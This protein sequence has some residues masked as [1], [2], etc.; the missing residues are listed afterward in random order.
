MAL[1]EVGHWTGQPD[2]LN[3]ATLAEGVAQ[4]VDSRAYP[5]EEL[6]AELHSYLSGCRL[7]V[8][9]DPERHARFAAE[10][11][12]TLRENPREFCRAAWDA[13]RISR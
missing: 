6:R 5:R 13:E 3:R 11:A 9:H 10:W 12:A 7:A 1:H 4:G 8:G 2:R